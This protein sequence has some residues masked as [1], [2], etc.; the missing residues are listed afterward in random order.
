MSITPAAG[1]TRN[2]SIAAIAHGTGCVIHQTIAH[3]NVASAIRPWYESGE[4]QGQDES[5]SR[6]TGEQF[7]QV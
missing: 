7:E 1:K 2:G 3:T 5:E 4:R 6:R